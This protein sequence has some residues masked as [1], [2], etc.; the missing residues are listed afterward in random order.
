MPIIH[1][2]YVK[3][4][5][6]YAPTFFGYIISVLAMVTPLKLLKAPF[7][8]NEPKLIQIW[9]DGCPLVKISSIQ[10]SMPSFKTACN[11]F[12]KYLIILHI[13]PANMKSYKKAMSDTISVEI[14]KWLKGIIYYFL[15]KARFASFVHNFIDESHYFYL[16]F[17]AC[18]ERFEASSAFSPPQLQS[19]KK[20]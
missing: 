2:K 3:P 20:I 15:L 7:C 6:T 12:L 1:I 10:P 11:Q 17:K 19:R 13:S 14:Y 18:H 8:K 16:K 5:A 4:I 9:S